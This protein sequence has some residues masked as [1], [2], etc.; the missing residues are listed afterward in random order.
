MLGAPIVLIRGFTGESVL[1]WVAYG[2]ALAAVAFAAVYGGV[3]V[4][5]HGYPWSRYL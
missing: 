1:Y 3:Y 2:V 4:R 5:N